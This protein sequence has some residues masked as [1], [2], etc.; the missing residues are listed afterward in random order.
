MP[1]LSRIPDQLQS[2]FS[3]QGFSQ[4]HGVALPF[5]TVDPEGYPRA[6]LL[7]FGEVR[8]IS[9][10]ELVVAVRAGSRTAANLIRRR[11]AMLYYLGRHSAIWVQVRAGRGHV[12]TADPERHIFPLSVVRVKVDEAGA[13][14]EGGSLLTGPIFTVA[15]PDRIFSEQLFEELGREEK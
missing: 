9:R 10:R 11:V 2:L 6:A 3:G 5:V 4:R 8:A 1:E 12:S 7:S 13:G 14:E 15:E